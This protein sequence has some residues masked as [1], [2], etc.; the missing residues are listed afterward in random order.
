MGTFYHPL[1]T[2]C[3]HVR[4]TFDHIPSEGNLLLG[5][6]GT[7]HSRRQHGCGPGF[8]HKRATAFKRK[9]S[10]EYADWSSFQKSAGRKSG[11]D[12]A[13]RENTSNPQRGCSPQISIPCNASLY[14]MKPTAPSDRQSSC[15]HAAA[16]VFLKKQ[17]TVFFLEV[18]ESHDG[19]AAKRFQGTV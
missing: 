3:S 14:P 7:T 1:Q 8:N 11:T 10:L 18:I 15:G 17:W 9:G 5:S 6:T 13:K 19:V 2:A 16:G 12:A 4:L